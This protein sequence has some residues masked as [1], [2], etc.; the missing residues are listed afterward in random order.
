MQHILKDSDISDHDIEDIF[1]TID[2]DGNGALEW[3]EFLSFLSLSPASLRLV[4]TKLQDA[5]KHDI[6][7]K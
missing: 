5:F 1:E 2:Q 3:E 4:I 6:A 7:S